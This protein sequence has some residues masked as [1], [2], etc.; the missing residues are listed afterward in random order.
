MS[1]TMA[2]RLA[3]VAPKLCK[4]D[5][6]PENARLCERIG[7]GLTIVEARAKCVAQQRV[8]GFVCHLWIDGVAPR[9]ACLL[10]DATK[11]GVLCGCAL[12][13]GWYGRFARRRRRRRRGRWRRGWSHSLARG[14]AIVCARRDDPLA[15]ARSRKSHRHAAVAGKHV[16][17]RIK[18]PILVHVRLKGQ[19]IGIHVA[20]GIGA[21]V[22]GW[23]LQPNPNKSNPIQTITNPMQSNAI[24]SNPIQLQI[25][26]YPTQP[27]GIKI[28]PNPIHSPI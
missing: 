27:N 4:V 7:A 6:G 25:N 26:A 24:Q 10:C 8:G 14:A 19:S 23:T 5:V 11:L 3:I 16:C 9:K 20:L 15:G 12:Q 18:R 28:Q 17:K 2:A 22:A 13:S 21:D 1:H